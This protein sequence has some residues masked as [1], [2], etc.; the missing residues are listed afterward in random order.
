FFSVTILQFCFSSFARLNASLCHSKP[1][2][3]S[4]HA[5]PVEEYEPVFFQI[6]RWCSLCQ[7]SVPPSTTSFLSVT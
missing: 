5:K 3:C 6:T 4:L 7:A 1:S 2:R